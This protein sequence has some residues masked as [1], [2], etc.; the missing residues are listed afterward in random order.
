MLAIESLCEPAYGPDRCRG[1]IKKELD[2]LL[3]SVD[4][5]DYRPDAFVGGLNAIAGKLR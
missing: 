3:R 4:R 1:G 5:F 2:V